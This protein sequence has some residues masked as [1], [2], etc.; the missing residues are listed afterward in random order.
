MPLRALILALL[1]VL[2]AW[3]L[4]PIAAD[5]ARHA[6][7][8]RAT[9]ALEGT[10]PDPGFVAYR[11]AYLAAL[12]TEHA[13]PLG[14]AALR[15]ELGR[16]GTVLLGDQHD[17]ARIKA[18][19][20][21][22]LGAMRATGPVTLAIE[23][24]RPEFQPVLDAYI[25][26]AI[27]LGALRERAYQPS[28]W[29]FAWRLYAPLFEGARRLG[30]RVVAVEPG[31]HLDLPARDAGIAAAVRAIPGRVLVFYGSFHLL[32]AGHLADLLGAELT[33]TPS[34]QDRY[35][36]LARHHGPSFDLLRL[37][38]RVVFANLGSP[39]EQDTAALRD[40]MDMFGYTSFHEVAHDRPE[41][42]PVPELPGGP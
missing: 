10:A 28:H 21:E 23:F 27:D 11:E 31:T 25:S 6:W 33:I 2:P 4:D 12:D 7:V 39:L 41:L 29:S 22:C 13:R 35:W 37:S 26:G 16:A 36:E 8:K 15:Q 17:D 14:R 18:L 3:A 34:A 5:Q 20:L 24:I 30:V 9:A 19:A 38:G 42:A 1:L 40:L 32:G